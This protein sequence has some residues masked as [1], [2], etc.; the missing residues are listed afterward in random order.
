MCRFA[1]L[2]LA[3]VMLTLGG[4]GCVDDDADDSAFVFDWQLD[5]IGGGAAECEDA[6]MS[7]VEL[8]ARHLDTKAIYKDTF[9]CKAG[10]GMSRVLPVGLYSVVIRLRDGA[11]RV[12]SELP[13]GVA[14]I[15]RVG[16]SDLG[17]VFFD[18]QSFVLNWSVCRQ[19]AGGCAPVRC[20]DVGAKSVELLAQPA[21]G[22][23]LR[24]QW[25]C[26]AGAGF[27]SVI[28]T[29]TYGIQ[30]RL[31]DSAGRELSGVGGKTVVVD[32]TAR[33]VLPPLTFE[34]R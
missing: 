29:G 4:A 23:P 18:I 32:D 2:W 6:G 25:D 31:L 21:Q 22:D 17:T 11:G 26:S 34:V 16:L 5:F 13:P 19:G 27:S 7:T 14:D 15:T 28:L 8:E 20:A 12:V 33:A 10:A 9:A 1:T 24:E 3:G 30:V